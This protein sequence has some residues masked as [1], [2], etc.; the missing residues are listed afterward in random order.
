[1]KVQVKQQTIDGMK[2]HLVPNKK[3]KTISLIAKLRAPL[4]RDTV[5]KRALLPYVLKQGTASF[6]T[7][8]DLQ[9]ELDELYG[10]TLAITGGKKGE[11]HILTIRLEVAN[12]KFIPDAST[13]MRRAAMLFEEVLFQ[14]NGEDAF[15]EEIFEREKKTLL[16][17]IHALKDDKMNYANTR[18]MDEMCEVEPYSL[19]VQ[20][21]EDD[22][23]SLQNEDLFA[24][25]KS[26]IKE[27]TMD[28]YVTGDFQIKEMMELMEELLSGKTNQS[29]K[30]VAP[31]KSESSSSSSPKEIVEEDTV[32]QAKLH[33]GYRTNILFEDPK[34]AALQVFN[35]LFGAF[36]SSKLFINVRE[37]NS[38]AYYASSRLE[39]H[40]G[41]MVVMSGIAPEDYVKARDIIREQVEEMKKGSFTDEE[42]EETKQLIINQLLETMDHPQGLVELLYQQEVGGKI[43]PPEQLIKDIK[44]VTK[45][46][47]IEVAKEIEEDTVYLLTS[48]GGE[49]NE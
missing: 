31:S 19:H 17:K 48:K 11:N 28:V 37:K 39:S 18:L 24:Y 40:K 30:P 9:K 8:M 10:A 21:Y 36:P 12:E 47:V 35:G 26:I 4:Q 34:Y 43:L 49:K 38:L 3:H 2:F 41:L 25:A 15:K 46:Q 20:G 29:N 32:Q 44:S 27:D 22:L 45:Q 23:I 6:P 1:M 16:Q 13:V 14:L 5:T 33:I 42:F 7:R